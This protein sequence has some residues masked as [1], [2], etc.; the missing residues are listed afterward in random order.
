MWNACSW[1]FVDLLVEGHSVETGTIRF[2]LTL[3]QSQS[4][5]I[6]RI[7]SVDL[8]SGKNTERKS[9]QCTWMCVYVCACV[10]VLV[11]VYKAQRAC[12]TWKHEVAKG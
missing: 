8:N 2:V 6:S 11:S 1:I 10:L 5:I 12:L 4:V 7:V 3:H 9:K